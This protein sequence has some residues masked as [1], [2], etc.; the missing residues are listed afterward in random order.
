M[1][2]S[3]LKVPIKI[4]KHNRNTDREYKKAIDKINTNGLKNIKW[5]STSLTMER[6]PIRE[7][8]FLPD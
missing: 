4:I 3:S 7:F 5:Y 8:I 1:Y 2:K 6:L